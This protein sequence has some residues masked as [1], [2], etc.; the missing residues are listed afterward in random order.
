MDIPVVAFLVRHPSAGDVL[1]DTGFHPSVAVEPKGALGKWGGLLFKDIRMATEDSLPA[2]LRA[3]GVD[4]STIGTVVMTHLHFDHAGAISEF[5]AATFAVDAREWAA[6]ADGSERDG[7]IRRQFDHGFD[8]RL[9][10]FDGPAADS[11]ATFGRAVDLFGDGSVRLVSTPGHSAGH[12]SVVL[13]L[14]EREALLCGDAA[15]TESAIENDTVPYVVQDEHFYL[16]SLREIQLYTE[17]TP[18]ALVVPGHELAVM[19]RAAYGPVNPSAK[20]GPIPHGL[21]SVPPLRRKRTSAARPSGPFAAPNGDRCPGAAARCP[22]AAPACPWRRRRAAA[23]CPSRR[24]P[25]RSRPRGAVGT[26]YSGVTSGE[27]PEN[28]AGR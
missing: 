5:P 25:S 18:D 6:A 3:L 23:P 7:Y 16:R 22:W 12:L 17:Q 1:V 20:Q 4:P 11:F 21:M 2:Q 15:Y 14:R 26:P 28:S 9:V 10:D 13:R 24:S 27:R 19:R 8:W